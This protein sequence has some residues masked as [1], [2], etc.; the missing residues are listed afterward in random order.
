MSVN[1]LQNY[2]RI[3]SNSDKLHYLVSSERGKYKFD[4]SRQ[5]IPSDNELRRQT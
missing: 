1:H 2:K 4:F 3:D 5:L